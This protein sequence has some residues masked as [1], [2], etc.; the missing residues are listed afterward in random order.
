MLSK[1]LPISF[2]R[3]GIVEQQTKILIIEDDSELNQQ[4]CE[5]LTSKGYDVEQCFDGELGLMKA[6]SCQYSLIVLDV[7]LPKRDGISLLT[8]LRKT[9]QTPV[10]M[11]TAKGAEQERIIG[12]TQGADDYVSK[13]FNPTELILRIEALLRRSLQINME[14]KQKELNLDNLTLDYSN[15]LVSVDGNAIDF[16]PIQFKLLWELLLHKGE[17]LSKAY[18]Y[19]QVLNRNIGAYDRSLDM[20]LSRL[21]KK[22]NEANGPGERL[23]TSHGKGYCLV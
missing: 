13:P 5:L 4:L 3:I 20:H 6:A 14:V 22:L 1:L 19:Q 18:L 17:T 16:T 9:S 10:I 21:R 8:M 12:F 2:G 11:V 23:Q 15:Q 7:M